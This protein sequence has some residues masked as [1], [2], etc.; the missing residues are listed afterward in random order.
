MEV[1]GRDGEDA[2]NKT[3]VQ[4]PNR[5]VINYRP[6]GACKSNTVA[7]PQLIVLASETPEAQ[8]LSF[9]I[10]GLLKSELELPH[11]P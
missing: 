7:P 4:S 9:G 8:D 11:T 2:E 10:D 1:T 6:M 5:P 3:P